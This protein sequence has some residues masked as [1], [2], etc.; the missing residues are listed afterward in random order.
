MLIFEILYSM[1]LGSSRNSKNIRELEQDLCKKLAVMIERWINRSEI[2]NKK[3]NFIKNPQNQINHKFK[4]I[5]S[6]QKKDDRI[7][8]VGQGEYLSS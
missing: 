5:K 8:N 4:Q 7:V 6:Q 3:L 2:G 1:K